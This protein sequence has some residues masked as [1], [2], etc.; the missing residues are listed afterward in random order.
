MRWGAATSV[1]TDPTAQS[2][3]TLAFEAGNKVNPLAKKLSAFVAL[4]HNDVSAIESVC[5]T[6]RKLA[7]NEVLVRE[8]SRPAFVFLILEGVA[9]RYKYLANGKRQI[10]GYMLPG[11]LCDAHFLV[12]NHIDH[13]IGLLTDAEVAMISFHD[14]TGLMATSPRIR[15]AL[16]ETM[17]V[18]NAVLREWLLN[19]GQRNARQKLAH[20]ICEISKRLSALGRVNR[21]GSYDVPLTQV[22]L[23]DTIGLTVVHVSRCLQQFRTEKLMSWSRRHLTIEDPA[24]LRQLAGFD[25]SYLQVGLLSRASR[26]RACN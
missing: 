1:F 26:P 21:D 23:A 10:M 18:E 17:I 3:S 12:S 16:L 20:F 19:V 9:Y 5:R 13:D 6:R 2:V 15:E 24:R 22:E 14:L 11:D 25:D 7:A 8:G 4:S